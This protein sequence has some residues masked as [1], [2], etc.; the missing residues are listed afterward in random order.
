MIT[1]IAPPTPAV[2]RLSSLPDW[3]VVVVADKKTPSD[4]SC[5]GVHFLSI[6]KQEALGY[7][8]SRLVPWNS[9][10]YVVSLLPFFYLEDR[11]PGI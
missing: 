2:T 11:K 9:Y 1:S 10:R 3:Q 4:W 7:K 8:T 5:P 6:E